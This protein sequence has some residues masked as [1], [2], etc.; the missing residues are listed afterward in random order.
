MPPPF[1]GNTIYIYVSICVCMKMHVSFVC[2]CMH[3]LADVHYI[4]YLTF[5]E[6]DIQQAKLSSPVT[7]HNRKK[8]LVISQVPLPYV[9]DYYMYVHQQ[10]MF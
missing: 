4:L 6:L 5:G 2:I 8:R 9:V 7:I 10:N 3:I 1:A